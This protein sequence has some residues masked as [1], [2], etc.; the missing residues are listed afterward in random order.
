MIIYG[1]MILSGC[2][3]IGLLI[4]DLLGIAIHVDAN[5][6]GVG[7][8]MIG[9]ILVLDYLTKHEKISKNALDGIN[10]WNGM[11]IPIV[12]AMTASQNV[13]AAI[14]GGMV[15]LVA[16]VLAVIVG[17]ILLPIINKIN[18]DS[19]LSENGKKRGDQSC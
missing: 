18:A 15:A 14:K 19:N 7:F 16:G 10:F 9:L 17:F 3:L 4:G 8:A 5:V 11:Y 12:V 6:G 2:T 13:L 1:L